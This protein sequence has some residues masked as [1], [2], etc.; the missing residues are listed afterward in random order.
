MVDMHSTLTPEA[1]KNGHLIV[2]G[3]AGYSAVDHS[4]LQ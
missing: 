1:S 4:I 3:I 2:S